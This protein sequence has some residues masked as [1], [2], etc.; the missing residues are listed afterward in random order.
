MRIVLSSWQHH[1]EI[2]LEMATR[3]QEL[4]FC[5]LVMIYHAFQLKLLEVMFILCPSH[6]TLVTV[7]HCRLSQTFPIFNHFSLITV[8]NSKTF[9]GF[10]LM[11][12]FFCIELLSNPAALRRLRSIRRSVSQAV[13]LSLVTSLIMTRLDYGSAVLAGLPSH[14]LNRLQ[15]VLNAAARL[16]C[17]A[18]KY[19]HV[20][21]LLRD[22]HWL[23]VPERIQFRLAVLA[24]CCRNHKAPSYLADELHWTDEAESW[25]RLQ[26]GSCPCLIVPRT[27]LSTI[28]D[29]SCRVTVARAWNRLP[30][31]ITALT[32]LPFFNRQLKTF[33]FTKSFPSV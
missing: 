24:F 15:S 7:P 23:R 31:S 2:R 9:P 14:L 1:C 18:R 17:R 27:R 3:P 22:L 19:D 33:L 11:T 30:T 26:S 16:V 20:T 32:S 10:V 29:R 21:H 5:Q 6:Y 12:D 13:L 4:Q 25:H 8:Q 28:G